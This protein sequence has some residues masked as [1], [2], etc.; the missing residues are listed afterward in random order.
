MSTMF[1]SFVMPAKNVASYI[2]DA[3]RP[4]LRTSLD[5]WEL[6]IVDDHSSDNT[7]EVARS[8]AGHDARVIAVSNTGNGKIAGLNCGYA[9]AR[10]SVIK[11]IDADDQL[12]PEFFDHVDAMSHCDAMCHDMCVTDSKLRVMGK[13]A[14]DPSFFQNDFA[15]CLK[16][17]KSLPRCTWSFTREVGN[18]IFPMP[19]ELPFEDVWFSLSIKRYAAKISYLNEGLYNYRQHDN[20]TFGGVLSFSDSIVVFRAQRMLR[21]LTVIE[22]EDGRSLTEG[23]VLSGFFDEIK[24]FYGLLGQQHVSLK[25]I[26]GSDMPVS[27]RMKVLI[28]KKLSLLAPHMVRLKWLLDRAR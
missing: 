26:L 25:S 2:A 8:V 27:L 23:I 9:F 12:L 24:R 10:G 7:L 20:Q 15:Y 1:V 22:S 17:L 3:I 13:Y 16:Y 11:C 6:I 28:Y 14:M 5:N 4:L 18:R 21:L 19:L